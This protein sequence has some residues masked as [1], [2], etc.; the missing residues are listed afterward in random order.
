MRRITARRLPDQAGRI[1]CQHL[2]VRCAGFGRGQSSAEPCSRRRRLRRC[3]RSRWRGP[4]RRT[5]LPAAHGRSDSIVDRFMDRMDVAP[6]SAV[7]Q[8]HLEGKRFEGAGGCQPDHLR[9]V[10]AA[11]LSDLNAG[12]SMSGCHCRPRR[13]SAGKTVWRPSG[14]VLPFR[15]TVSTAALTSGR[16]STEADRNLAGDD[17]SR[18]LGPGPGSG[19]APARCAA[20]P[21]PPLAATGLNT[22]LIPP[23]PS[24]RA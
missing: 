19:R 22:L 8:P 14:F 24:A 20:A 3:G 15:T 9:G 17:S 7:N 5:P 2:L 21:I 6:A 12:D 11:V 16:L 18:V 4:T 13:G 23:T 1:R 10:T